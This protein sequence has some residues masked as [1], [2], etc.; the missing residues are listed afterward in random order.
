MAKVKKDNSGSNIIINQVVLS[1][2]QRTKL[3]IQ[4]WRNNLVNAEGIYS[5][6]RAALYDMYY[7]IVLDAHLA[8]VI[9]KRK[10]PVLNSKVLFMRNGDV[11]ETIQAQVESPWFRK[12]LNDYLDT[13]SWGYSVFQFRREGEWISYDLIPRK[14]IRPEKGLLLKNQY[15]RSGIKYRDEYQ[16][17]LEAGDPYD[18]GLLVRAAVYVIYKRNGLAD[19]AQ[20]AELFGQPIR[21][22]VYDAFDDQAR[23]KLRQDME[24]M[25]SSAIFIHPDGTKI[26]LLE[27]QQKTGGAQLYG[28]I[29]NFCN[30][31]ISKLYLGNTLT[32]EQGEKG[33]RSLGDVHLEIEHEKNRSDKQSILHTLNYDLTEIFTNL[34]LNVNGGEFMFEQKEKLSMKDNIEIDVQLA[35]LIPLDDNYFYEAYNRPK[36]DNYEQLRKEMDKRK[37]LPPVPR[38]VPDS[39]PPTNRL[40]SA[41]SFFSKALG[42]RAPLD[43]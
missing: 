29:L 6:N 20:F 8:S 16:N 1:Q 37:Q 3:D 22:G 35:T 14:H 7:D 4:K 31:E 41:F 33:A 40:K 39:E 28:T 42:R 9:Q 26:N 15:D 43:F 2:I 25:G 34:G 23:I 11:D 12:F 27:T 30:S 17:I 32:T 18:L 21:E 24:N 13:I 10:D 36:P 38:H 5:P 19:L